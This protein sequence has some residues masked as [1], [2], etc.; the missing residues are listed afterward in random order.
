LL[1]SEQQAHQDQLAQQ[2]TKAMIADKRLSEMESLAKALKPTN[3][4]E[5]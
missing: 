4:G 3:A 5:P 1:T 2:I